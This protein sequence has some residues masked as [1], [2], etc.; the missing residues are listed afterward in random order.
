MT[1]GV[2]L[3]R[4]TEAGLAADTV[5]R[6]AGSA[7]QVTPREGQISGL[8]GGSSRSGIR[9]DSSPF[10]AGDGS[11]FVVA[12]GSRFEVRRFRPNVVVATDGVESRLAANWLTAAAKLPAVFACVLENGALG[13]VLLTAPN[14]GCLLCHRATQRDRGQLDPEPGIDLGYGTGSRHRPMTAVLVVSVL[15]LSSSSSP[16]A[17]SPPREPPLPRTCPLQLPRAASGHRRSSP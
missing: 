8:I 3:V 5:H 14:A 13:E 17:P 1:L 11:G 10:L 12:H 15:V 4:T 16:L 2:L 9:F 7:W 6:V